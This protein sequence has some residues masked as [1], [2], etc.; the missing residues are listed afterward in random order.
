MPKSPPTVTPA[1]ALP[2]LAVSSPVPAPVYYDTNAVL[3]TVA[4]LACLET[5]YAR[6]GGIIANLK[7]HIAQFEGIDLATDD[8]RERVNSTMNQI[9]ECTKEMNNVPIAGQ[10][11][12]GGLFAQFNAV[13][14]YAFR[15]LNVYSQREEARNTAK[16]AEQQAVRGRYETIVRERDAL[17]AALNRGDF[18][19]PSAK[20]EALDL[21][22]SLTVDIDRYRREHGINPDI[23]GST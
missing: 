3:N 7:D 12:T 21:V 5:E 17:Q 13:I 15:V 4:A 14:G 8:D 23:K 22:R 1:H 2:P 9:V 20:T 16:F 10:M 6:V 18:I 19:L 11:G